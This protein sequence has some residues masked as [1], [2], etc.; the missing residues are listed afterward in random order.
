MG[1]P[2][3][4]T[5]NKT[6]LT[7]LPIPTKGR[8]YYYDDRTPGF[9]FCITDKGKRAFYYCAKVRGRSIRT[10][11]GPFPGLT[12]E[13]ARDIAA[14]KTGGVAEGV[15]PRRPSHS[16]EST[17]KDLFDHW[18]QHAKLR[19]K[20][21]K[22]DERIFN[23]YFVR[24]K[25]RR[26]T[27]LVT[28][29]VATWHRR[30]GEKHGP[31]QANRARALLSAM[32]AKAPELG[33]DGRNPCEGVKRFREMERERFLQPDEMK[34]F[35]LALKEEPA[36]WRDFWLL[37]LFSGARR[38]N[39]AS[40]AWADIDLTAG[41]WY[42]P[43]QKTKNGLPVAI[44]LPPPAVAILMT[45]RDDQELGER[46]VFPASTKPG[47]VVDPRKSWARVLKRSGIENLRP[48]DLRR[49]LGSWQ[50]IAGAS[51]QIVG[52]SLGHRDPK[53]TAV[54]AR[55]QLDPVRTSVNGVVDSM[56]AAGGEAVNRNLLPHDGASSREE[57][58]EAP[59]GAGPDGSEE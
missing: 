36:T 55:L 32:W 49:S 20:T 25:S 39:V 46:W 2:A 47:H 27:E 31:Y 28:A 53:A 17:V 37:C 7:E 56:I 10:K 42:L 22:D 30:I 48:H 41:V 54:Y 13:Q 9:A 12:V 33:H 29:D 11:I 57:T 21:W 58:C 43:G 19:K 45:R 3:R 8:K 1:E 51:L 4:L 15:D 14:K 16:D 50:A 23:K 35:F 38:G 44:V 5:F 6:R 34:P 40:M 24:L 59:A 18:F 52:A 26:L